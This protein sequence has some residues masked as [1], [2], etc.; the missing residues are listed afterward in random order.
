MRDV[1]PAAVL[2]AAILALTGFGTPG[3]AAAQQPTSLSVRAEKGTVVPGGDST[4]A[5]RSRRSSTS[6]SIRATKSAVLPGNAAS[7]RGRLRGESQAGLARRRVVL[8]AK[9]AGAGAWQFH[10]ARR[11]D[12]AGRVHFLIRPRTHTQYR[13]AFAGTSAY[14]PSR[15]GVVDVRMRPVVTIAADSV[16]LDQ[17]QSTAFY[18]TVLHE[19]G[20]VAGATVELLER[21]P[22][23]SGAEWTVIA[24]TTTDA[25]GTATVLSGPGASTDYR[26]R[27]SPVGEVPAGRS[28]SLHV[29]VRAASSLEIRGSSEPTVGFVVEG[30]LMAAS[31]A[32]ADAA[33]TLQ[34]YDASDAGWKAVS[35]TLTGKAGWVR[36][37]RPYEAGASY[38]LVYTGPRFAPSTSAALTI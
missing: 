20:P 37:V 30:R 13:F 38:R 36:F 12:R 7:L 3:P 6:I 19:T 23:G 26:W 14:R 31:R 5:P 33:V 11:T 28:G 18:V 9:S 4:V 29:D 34:A 32:V 16:Q 21:E 22:P 8:L 27:S 2:V 24:S 35:T 25:D 17:G 10:Q 1:R 15:S